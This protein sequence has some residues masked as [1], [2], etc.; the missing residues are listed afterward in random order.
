MTANLPTAGTFTLAIPPIVLST[1]SG[2]ASTLRY[3]NMSATF[4]AGT[5][6][7]RIIQRA[8]KLG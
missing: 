6:T 4:S 7:A 3:A 1:Q 5:V 2:T 8:I